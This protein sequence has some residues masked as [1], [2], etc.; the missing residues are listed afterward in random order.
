MEE[1]LKDGKVFV[2]K[3]NTY[4]EVEEQGSEGSDY[5]AGPDTICCFV[6][7]T[8]CKIDRETKKLRCSSM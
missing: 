4:Y 5:S 7:K 1:K 8:S 3:D 6:K 2:G